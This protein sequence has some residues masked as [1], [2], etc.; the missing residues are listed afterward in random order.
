MSS[1]AYFTDETVQK[2]TVRE[3]CK[4]LWLLYLRGHKFNHGNAKVKLISIEEWYEGLKKLGRQDLVYAFDELREKV[5]EKERL[6][7]K[8]VHK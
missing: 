4:D 8:R 6:D 3:E 2:Y 5:F 7:G 1:F